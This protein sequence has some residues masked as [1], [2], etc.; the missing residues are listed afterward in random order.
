MAAITSINLPHDSGWTAF[1]AGG[2]QNDGSGNSEPTSRAADRGA[3]YDTAVTEDSTNYTTG[4]IFRVTFDDLDGTPWDNGAEWRVIYDFSDESNYRY[5]KVLWGG[6]QPYSDVYK[7][8]VQLWKVVSGTHSQITPDTASRYRQLEPGDMRHYKLQKRSTTFY[9][10]VTIMTCKDQHLV[11][12]SGYDILDH[13]RDI[14]DWTILSAT[15]TRTVFNGKVGVAAIASSNTIVV[16]SVQHQQVSCYWT[17]KTGNDSNVG[18]HTAP[19]LTLA[20]LFNTVPT[21]GYGFV[22]VGTYRESL[23]NI[24]SGAGLINPAT[25]T[26]YEDAIHISTYSTNVVLWEANGAV[27]CFYIKGYEQGIVLRGFDMDGRW[28]C[29]R[30]FYLWGQATGGSGLTPHYVRTQDGRIQR[31]YDHENVLVTIGVLTGTATTD[32]YNQYH[33]FIDIECDG[34]RDPDVETNG[35]SAVNGCHGFYL[36]SSEL[37][38][39]YCHIHDNQGIGGKYSRGSL[40]N[41]QYTCNNNIFRFNKT[42][43]NSF[44]GLETYNSDGCIIDF[45]FIYDDQ[46]LR[47]GDGSIFIYSGTK[48]AYVRNNVILRG[49]VSNG[50]QGYGASIMLRCGSPGTTTITGPIYVDGNSVEG[51]LHAGFSAWD[52]GGTITTLRLTNN[53]IYNSADVDIN[54]QATITTSTQANNHVTADGDPKFNS[55]SSPSNDLSLQATS[56]LIEAGSSQSWSHPY[57]FHLRPRPQDNGSNAY[58][59]G[60]YEYPEPNANDPVVTLPSTFDV[61]INVPKILIG[62]SVNDDDGDI[63]EVWGIVDNVTS[64]FSATESGGA[65]FVG[66]DAS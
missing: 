42:H 33:E 14:D 64:G 28:V 6:L 19:F 66:A 36:E 15:D 59:I 22:K 40:Y 7:D 30:L 52:T 35:S 57:D 27:G 56:P 55:P 34:G 58:D 10:K 1:A 60:A 18:S 8:N 50:D 53:V 51:A 31:G 45:N 38:V 2:F 23:S 25:S 61:T 54:L 41:S 49:G 4:T 26:N 24:H 37:L 46:N 44:G 11:K 9:P 32:D 5:V 20:K 3:T 21:N 12:V 65:T 48:T 16:K 47:S 13:D 29:D 43:D 39:E 17:A 62:I 63:D